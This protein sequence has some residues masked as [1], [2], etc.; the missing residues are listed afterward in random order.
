MEPRHESLLW[1]ALLPASM[2]VF[3]FWLAGFF[4]NLYSLH[5]A[6]SRAAAPYHVQLFYNL[7]HGRPFQIS[8]EHYSATTGVASNPSGYVNG[9]GYGHLTFS[10]ALLAI[11]FALWPDLTGLYVIWLLLTCGAF[12]LA[13]W[14]ILGHL[15]PEDRGAKFRLAAAL[16]FLSPTLS[17]LQTRGFPMLV[18]GT[19]GP[20]AAHD[21]LLRRRRWQ[22]WLAVALLALAQEDGA[23]FA[24]CYAAFACAFEGLS[25]GLP[26]FLGS[27]F[28]FLAAILVLQP[29]ARFGL[30]SSQDST[31]AAQLSGS[32]LGGVRAVIAGFYPSDLLPVV[33]LCLGM[34]IA[35]AWFP[36]RRPVSLPRILGLLLLAPASGWVITIL[37]R[38]G[39]HIIPIVACAYLAL[40][41]VLA[42]RDLTRLPGPGQLGFARALCL[43][44]AW[45]LYASISVYV[46]RVDVPWFLREGLNARLG[47]EAQT[48]ID[49]AAEAERAS[50]REVLAL[51]RM[52]P[53]EKSMVLWANQDLEGFLADR[54]DLWRF[55]SLFGRAEVLVIQ[56]D[57]TDTC[58]P[59]PR[60]FSVSPRC[61]LAELETSLLRVLA[62][63]RTSVEG[64][65]PAELLA[66]VRSLLVDELKTHGVAVETPHAL[67]LQRLRPEPIPQPPESTGLGWVAH[68]PDVLRRQFHRLRA[69]LGHDG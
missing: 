50:N 18:A 43:T 54:S 1:R 8:I 59:L 58:F 10:T 21:G 24:G 19:L 3:A 52:V 48:R 33:V 20:L 42:S 15:A 5:S 34:A 45:L 66:R 69:M 37:Q 44:G 4:C 12:L 6:Y 29:A 60:D 14:S 36:P 17:I 64:Q 7:L 2:L 16:F 51:A 63:E 57:A 61:G 68:V 62:S 9:L 46:M 28:Y 55:L 40:L 25:P 11:P 39:H 53:R 38:G 31:A 32:A 26:A 13:A 35:C 27:T 22:F 23:M 41:E 49:R 30:N 67:I 65:V 56:K 47:R